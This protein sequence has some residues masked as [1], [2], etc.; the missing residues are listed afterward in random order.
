MIQEISAAN[1]ELSDNADQVARAVSELD[2][3]IQSNAAASEEMASTSQELSSQAIQLTE[4]VG[5]FGMRDGRQLNA[6]LSRSSQSQHIGTVQTA[7][8]SA[9]QCK[10]APPVPSAARTGL[11]LNMEENNEFERF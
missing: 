7:L 3:V 1:S 4:A 10:K 6:V 11:S 9:P 2:T 5:Y 8:P